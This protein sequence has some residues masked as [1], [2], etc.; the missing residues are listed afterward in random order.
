[1]KN[2]RPIF[3]LAAFL[4]IASTARADYEIRMTIT[5]PNKPEPKEFVVKMQGTRSRTE[6]DNGDAMIADQKT[7]MRVMLKAKTKQATDMSAFIKSIAEAK[8]KDKSKPKLTPTGKKETVAGYEAEEFTY[9][10][11]DDS[12]ISIWAA[13]DYPKDKAEVLMSLYRASGSSAY[14]ELPDLTVLPGPVIRSVVK[15][16]SGASEIDS[17]VK[18]VT[19]TKIDDKEFEIPADY[20][21]KKL[22][23]RPAARKEAK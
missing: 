23:A 7:G 12:K 4:A 22:P 11:N 5:S 17:V 2:F 18:S 16:K 14:A 6:L 19:E 13:K 9:D 3:T 1:M 21:V 15:D 20:T 8:D 10:M